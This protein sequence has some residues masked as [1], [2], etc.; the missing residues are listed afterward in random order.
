MRIQLEVIRQGKKEE[1][2]ECDCSL[3]NYKQTVQ[4]L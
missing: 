2:M 1:S 4:V 3:G